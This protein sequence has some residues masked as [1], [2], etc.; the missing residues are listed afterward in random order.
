[1]TIEYAEMENMLAEEMEKTENLAGEKAK[2]ELKLE[3]LNK[4]AGRGTP[5]SP[6]VAGR[7]K[8]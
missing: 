8:E 3:R 6:V 2:L 7:G 1:M 4:P 5:A